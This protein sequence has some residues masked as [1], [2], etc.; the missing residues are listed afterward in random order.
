MNFIEQFRTHTTRPRDVMSL[1]SV[2]QAPGESLKAY[3]QR[4]Q[5]AAIEV[6]NPNNHAILMAV[7]RGV[8][9]DSEFRDWL[10]GKP[11]ATLERVYSKAH[12]FIRR[13][14]ARWSRQDKAPG[15]V[16]ET[17]KSNIAVKQT[18]DNSGKA[19][20]NVQNKPGQSKGSGGGNLGKKRET[21]KW[22]S[23]V[24]TYNE[25]TS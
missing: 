6:S 12:Q 13:E 11:P 10:A 22:K 25:Y 19:Q 5:V 8:D 21:G 20:V 7:M 17:V 15:P 24:P 4:F 14:E 3:L 2:I 23:R 18:S 9:P 1:S 16:Q